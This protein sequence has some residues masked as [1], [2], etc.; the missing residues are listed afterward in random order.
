MSKFQIIK[1]YIDEYDYY[2]LLKNGAPAD[3]FDSYAL[4]FAELI[5]VDNTVE[6]IAGILA[7]RLDR[8]FGNEVEPEK[9]I[10]VAEKIKEAMMNEYG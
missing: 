1:K 6:A 5:N 10:S 4:E 7:E 9:F 3:E 2:S 8:A